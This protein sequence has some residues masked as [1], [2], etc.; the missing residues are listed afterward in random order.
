MEANVLAQQQ[1]QEHHQQQQEHLQQKQPVL[2][3]QASSTTAQSAPPPRPAVAKDAIALADRDRVRL[4]NTNPA[5]TAMIRQVIQ[6]NWKQGIHLEK[7]IGETGHD[8]KLKGIPWHCVADDAVTARRLVLA[9]IRAMAQMG[10]VM[11]ASVDIV[12]M[13]CNA[14]TMYFELET[15]KIMD[16]TLPMEPAEMFA[17]TFDTLVGAIRL[18][19][20]SPIVIELI[21]QAILAKWSKGI[22]SINTFVEAT[23]FTLNGSIPHPSSKR[24]IEFKLV[25]L[26]I[27]ANLNPQ[28]FK[29]YGS[30]DVQ[31]NN[32]ADMWVFRRIGPGWS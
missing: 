10:W 28:G 26:Q 8:F 20:A 30:V 24:E 31:S 12:T 13:G 1:Q 6:Q 21:K 18:I 23:Q 25:L 32:G 14:D 11:M 4:I 3:P 9:M 16:P 15:R 2:Q 22:K 17:M 5:R 29:L 19:D 27:L 7:P